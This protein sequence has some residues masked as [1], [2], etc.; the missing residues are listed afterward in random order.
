MIQIDRCQYRHERANHVGCVQ[1]A[2][3]PG[4][5]DHEVNVL[6]PE[7]V[8][9]ECC[10]DLEKSWMTFLVNAWTNLLDT[11]HDSLILDRYAV[12]LNSLV[13]PDEVRRRKETSSKAG[14]P[15]NRLG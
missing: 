7:I 2:A 1:T 15:A 11:A 9:R 5:E 14:E 8:E 12:Y 6:C 13:K 4:F 3:E 10:R